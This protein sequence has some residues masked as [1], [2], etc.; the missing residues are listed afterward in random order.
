M[1]KRLAAAALV[2]VAVAGCT[3]TGP[4]L[5]N[6]VATGTVERVWEDGF[7]LVTAQGQS[8]QV[9]AWE[10]CGNQVRR[11]IGRGNTVTVYGGR[12]VLGINAWRITDARGRPACPASAAPPRG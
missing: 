3:T 4:G 5:W 8:Y 7:R 10:V 11:H 2:S 6:P 12:T 9:N 1:L